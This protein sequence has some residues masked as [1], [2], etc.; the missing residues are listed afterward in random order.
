MRTEALG[1]A[2]RAVLSN[3]QAIQPRL[4]SSRNS[5]AGASMCSWWTTRI[6][7]ESWGMPDALLVVNASPLIFLGNAGH[8]ELLHTMGA[9][10]I[11]GFSSS[12]AAAQFSGWLPSQ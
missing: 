8:L 5:R 12:E 9:S 10:R 6:S 1:H 4:G 3:G 2:G 11:L 7:P